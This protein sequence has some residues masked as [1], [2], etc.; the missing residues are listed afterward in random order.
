MIPAESTTTYGVRDQDLLDLDTV[1]RP[2]LFEGRVVLVSG[3]GSGIGKAIA[4]LF[5]RLGAR[6]V[7]C[8]RS[9]EKLATT[10]SLLEQIDAP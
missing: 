10:V 7:L 2:D 1:F 6:L 3:A 4:C 5:G 8:G 9:E